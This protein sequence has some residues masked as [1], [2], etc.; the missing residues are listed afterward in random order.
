MMTN[1]VYCKLAYKNTYHCNISLIMFIYTLWKENIIDIEW[2]VLND[3]KVNQINNV[4]LIRI[5]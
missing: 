1:A 3:D 5:G 4:F 2:L